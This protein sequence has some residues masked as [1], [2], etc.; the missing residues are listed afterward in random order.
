[1]LRCWGVEAWKSMGHKTIF[2]NFWGQNWSKLLNLQILSSCISYKL[3]INKW[4]LP[5][6]H[7]HYCKTSVSNFQHPPS[8]L[9]F[10]HWH[11]SVLCV[12][13]VGCAWTPCLFCLASCLAS[14]PI[15]HYYQHI[16]LA[17]IR[18]INWD[19]YMAT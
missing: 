13:G 17:K 9:F 1:M 8:S 5:P 6:A 16:Y 14:M 12:Y 10:S 7:D 19:S 11:E 4:D 15:E 3:V 18:I 2:Y